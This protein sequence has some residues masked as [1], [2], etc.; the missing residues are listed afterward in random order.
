MLA[1][2][3]LLCWIGWQVAIGCDCYDLR[4]LRVLHISALGRRGRS[5][6]G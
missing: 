5:F 2:I 6:R 4:M 1:A 3:L